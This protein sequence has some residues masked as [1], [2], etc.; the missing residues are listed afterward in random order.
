MNWRQTRLKF[1]AARPIQNG[2]GESGAEDNPDWPRYVR[3]TDIAGPRKLRD[4]VFA[5]L[6]PEVAH[7]ALLQSG[8]LLMTAAGATIGKS[9]LYRD[10]NPACFAGYLVRF[11]AGRDVDPRF[12]SY[13]TESL[14]YW[15][16]V[17]A[18][19]VMSTIENFSASKYQNL[20]LAIPPL[21]AQRDI[22][23]YLDRETAR[24]DALIA[25][26]RPNGGID[27]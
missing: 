12:V 25:A 5:S 21:A 16:Q 9:V 4:D 26:K 23:D 10:S 1:L 8:D 24:I 27:R 2:L 3:T 6:P 13:W 20:R 11:R 22:V 18:G 19:R 7:K 17:R 14:P 15:D